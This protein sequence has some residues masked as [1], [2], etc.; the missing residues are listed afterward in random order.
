MRPG[1]VCAPLRSEWA[2]LRG[3][4]ATPVVRTGRGPAHRLDASAGP[5]AVAGVAGG[6]DPRVL[7]GDLV[8]AQEIRRA[9]AVLPSKAAPLLYSALR[10]LGLRVHLGPIYSAQRVVDGPARVRLAATGAL[11]VD[12]ESAFLADAVP[13]GRTVVIR[14]IVDTLDAPLVHPGTV[15][16]GIRAL[17]ALRCAAPVLDQWS[18]AIGEREVLLFGPPAA[19]AP[20][21]PRTARRRAPGVDLVLLLRS[22]AA[23]DAAPAFDSRSVRV[24]GKYVWTAPS[25]PGR[26][27][28]TA[29]LPELAAN[30]GIPV[31]PVD[32][33]EGVDLALLRGARRIAVVA[34]ASAPPALT[35]D[36]LD[37]LTGLGPVRVRETTVADE[38]SFH[39]RE[40]S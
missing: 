10:H 12:T 32:S 3:A 6:L 26:E 39:P 23:A 7:P 25:T 28:L 18:A 36:L 13:D 11:A 27:C 21:G 31:H 35:T 5:I 16:R 38:L 20:P 30:Q 1:T 34:A 29:G 8:V 14:A 17:H 9:G 24:T 22:P 40:V 19:D 4:I 37:A 33:V 15:L 2:A